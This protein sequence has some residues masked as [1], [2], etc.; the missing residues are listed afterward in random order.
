MYFEFG[1]IAG[2]SKHRVFREFRK[3]TEPIF[4]VVWKFNEIIFPP[5]GL[6]PNLN[7]YLVQSRCLIFDLIL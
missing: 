7:F 3:R 6:N 2:S 5:K 4:I 1:E